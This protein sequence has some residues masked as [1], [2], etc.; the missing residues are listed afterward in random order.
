[1][2][3]EYVRPSEIEKRSFEIITRELEENGIEIDERYDYIIKRCIHTSADF[4]YAET[5]YFSD[6][7]V[8]AISDAIKSGCYIVTDTRMAWSGINKKF[9][10]EYGTEVCCFISDPDVVAMSVGHGG[11][12]ASFAMEKAMELDKPVV[13]V[14]GNAPTALVAIVNMKETKGFEPV[15][16]VG[17]PVGFVNVE[18]SKEMLIESGIPCIV[19]KGRKGGSNIAAC[20]INAIQYK[21]RDRG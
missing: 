18:A 1:M 21:D 16:V 2:E 13:F 11:T 9:L 10:E 17:V 15:A 20:I 12:R 5:M 6:G 14:V 8:E 7:A 4:D 3:L 19:N